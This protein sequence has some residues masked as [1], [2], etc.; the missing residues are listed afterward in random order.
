MKSEVRVKESPQ[1]TTGVSKHYS[2]STLL[3]PVTRAF[4]TLPYE[5]LHR[6]KNTVPLC[7][8]RTTSPPTS[9]PPVGTDLRDGYLESPSPREDRRRSQ[10]GLGPPSRL[11]S[12]DRTGSRPQDTSVYRVGT[13]P[14]PRSRVFVTAHEPSVWSFY[15]TTDPSRRSEG[16][17]KNLGFTL[18]VPNV[19]SD[20]SFRRKTPPTP[21]HLRLRAQPRT[22]TRNCSP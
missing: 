18:L 17:S 3:D 11:V 1:T 19:P 15:W 20:V 7:P 5:H 22:R 4:G 8:F 16:V 13:T 9:R 6:L 10:M 12:R 21:L 14:L 2:Q